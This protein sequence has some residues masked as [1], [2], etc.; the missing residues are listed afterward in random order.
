MAMLRKGVRFLSTGRSRIFNRQGATQL[1]FIRVLALAV[2]H[3]IAARAR[4]RFLRTQNARRFH[5]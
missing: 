4:R 1:L 2:P 5:G 3:I